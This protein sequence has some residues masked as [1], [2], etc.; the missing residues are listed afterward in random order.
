MTDTIAE[1]VAGATDPNTKVSTLLLRTIQAATG[2]DGEMVKWAEKELNGYDSNADCLGHRF[3]SGTIIAQDD[4]GQWNTVLGNI[5]DAI[6]TRPVKQGIPSF[7]GIVEDSSTGFM[8]A[9]LNAPAQE[10]LQQCV[11]GQWVGFSIQFTKAQFEAILASVR[12]S[13]LEW[14]LS[15]K[16]TPGEPDG[17][18][19]STPSDQELGT[20]Y[21]INV[22]GGSPNIQQG[23]PGSKQEI[24]QVV[25]IT[26]LLDQI[27]A[28]SSE[29]DE[30]SGSAVIASA[31]CFEAQV[32]SRSPNRNILQESA[33]VIRRVAEGVAAGQLPGLAE[34]LW[35]WVG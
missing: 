19:E 15:Q 6:T 32:R 24:D 26:E 9:E 29:L 21:V 23:S 12:Y 25:E 22:F 35:K 33:A 2:V 8:R 28:L 31:D 14:A 3:L 11:A 18:P 7:E 13:I 20:A 16:G 27:R 34:Q 1:L 30:E 4:S 5:M 10:Y 17:T